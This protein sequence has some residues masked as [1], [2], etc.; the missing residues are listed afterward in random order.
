L[1]AQAF[2]ADRRAVLAELGGR[3]PGLCFIARDSGGISGYLI[4]REGREAIQMG[5]VVA[6]N[7]SVAEQLMGALLRAAPGRRVFVDVPAP[8]R[9]GGEILARHGFTLQ[10]AF[11]RM[12]L[13][14]NG[15]P[16]QL[17]MVYGTSGAEKG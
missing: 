2:G 4:A 1:D 8:N 5:P 6:R 3:D 9:E 14:E 16:G 15:P 13:D 12:V 10:R 11:T 17:G 7:P